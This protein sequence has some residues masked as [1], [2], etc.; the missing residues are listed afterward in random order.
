MTAV[1]P[2]VV[3]V[4]V[5]AL[6]AAAPRPRT[7]TRVVLRPAFLALVY[8]LGTALVL[9]AAAPV[10]VV[11][12]QSHR[13]GE[14][15]YLNLRP[16]SSANSTHRVLGFSYPRGNARVFDILR[17]KALV[18]KR[19]GLMTHRRELGHPRSYVRYGF[20]TL[21]S[22]PRSAFTG[23]GATTDL[24]AEARVGW[25]KGRQRGQCRP[26]EYRLALYLDDVEIANQDLTMFDR[27]PR[28]SV[29]R[30]VI[31]KSAWNGTSL[32]TPRPASADGSRGD[33]GVR[34][35][36]QMMQRNVNGHVPCIDSTTLYMRHLKLCRAA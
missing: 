30:L 13:C 23:A 20:Q 18:L 1:D 31:P 26:A 21:P 17:G 16:S 15:M 27:K 9:L 22:I 29:I 24:I 2:A 4:A 32:A 35:T 5:P 7:P 11:E 3:T 36:L 25:L 33:D 10:A 19:N 6:V 12:A 28:P 34:L 14:F 8:L